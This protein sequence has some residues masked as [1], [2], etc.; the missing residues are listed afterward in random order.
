MTPG[1][2]LS[3]YLIRYPQ[4][5]G[6]TDEDPA[7]VLDRHHTP[8]YELVNDGVLLDRRRLLEHIGPTRKRVTGLRVEVAQALVDGDQIAARYRLVA[9]MRKGGPIATEIYMFGGAGCRR[10]ATPRHPGHPDT[11]VTVILA[12]NGRYR[13]ERT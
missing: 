8:D 1:S 9:E 13:K 10:P 3:A 5:A 7:T 2:D 11:P 12:G 4:E 6:L